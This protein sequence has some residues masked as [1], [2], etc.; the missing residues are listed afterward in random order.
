MRNMSK[1]LLKCRSLGYWLTSRGRRM[2]VHEKVLKTKIWQQI[3]SFEE[4]SKKINS[5]QQEW[6]SFAKHLTDQIT[7]LKEQNT[8]LKQSFKK[9]STMPEKS[10]LRP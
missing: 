3:Q 6:M 9:E 1:C 10:Q 4:T 7:A 2:R 8:D 5:E